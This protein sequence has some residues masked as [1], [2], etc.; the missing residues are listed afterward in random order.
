[1]TDGVHLRSSLSWYGPTDAAPA[2]LSP[3]FSESAPRIPRPYADDLF[4][5]AQ[6]DF[7][8]EYA[9]DKKWSFIETRPD[10]IIG[11]VPNENYYS[12]ATSVGFFLSLWKE[13]HGEGAECSFPGSRGTWKALSNDSSSDMIARQTIHLTLS[14][15][16]PKGAAYNVADSRTPS[17]W[18]VKWP[19]LCSYFGLKGTEPLPEPIDLR[20]F[21][22]DNMDT[23]LATEK[24]HGLQSG[25]IDSGR[26]M[27]IAEYYIMNKFDY[28]RQLDLTKI[29]STG[30]TEERTLK[31][32]WWTV[33]DRM[34]KAKL[35]P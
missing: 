21:I 15:F 31:E 2:L 30:F 12:I 20:K 18:E 23:W 7:I 16:T 14:P 4:Y 17:N 25:H 13:V 5:H 24:K 33:F 34:R 35:I 22:N 26:G 28:D 6:I 9:K 8:T 19:I 1:M 29:Y 27:R 11:F 10:F 32:T 3:P